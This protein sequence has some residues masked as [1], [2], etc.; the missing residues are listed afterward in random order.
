I[1]DYKAI[2]NDSDLTFILS[3]NDEATCINI[4]T[5][6]IVVQLQHDYSNPWV[7]LFTLKPEL[8]YNLKIS[9]LDGKSIPLTKQ[10]KERFL[11][12]DNFVDI[13]FSVENKHINQIIL[14]GETVRRL[15]SLW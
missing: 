14:E 11:L 1:V 8:L 3:D 6:T 4:E 12:K 9:L 7:R 5:E 10:S 2:T 13:H 15:C